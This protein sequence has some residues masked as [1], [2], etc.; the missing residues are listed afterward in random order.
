MPYQ[1]TDTPIIIIKRLLEGGR[2][3][4]RQISRETGISAPT[5]KAKFD[6]FVN[7]GFIKKVSPILDFEKVSY[8]I[9][10]TE[11]NNIK[12]QSPKEIEEITTGD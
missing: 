5:V 12:S 10:S 3:S 8:S 1:L 11:I 7:I 4:F 6:K 2:K 9:S